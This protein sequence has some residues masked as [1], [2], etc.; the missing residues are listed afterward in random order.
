MSIH[1]IIIEKRIVK[2]NVVYYVQAMNIYTLNKDIQEMI[3][4][5]YIYIYIY[6]YIIEN[7]N[8]D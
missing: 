4:K 1:E 7:H 5:L 8:I 6:I 3:I 2:I